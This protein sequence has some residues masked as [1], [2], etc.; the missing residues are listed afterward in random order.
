MYA[1]R[2][3]QEQQR[4]DHLLYDLLLSERFE[5]MEF[6]RGELEGPSHRVTF[7]PLLDGSCLV[8]YAGADYGRVPVY[9]ETMIGEDERAPRYGRLIF[10]DR[11]AWRRMARMLDRCEILSWDHRY[12]GGT[13]EASQ[14]YLDISCRGRRRICRAGFDA[15]PPPWE[16]FIRLLQ[17]EIDSRIS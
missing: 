9:D 17:R 12:H 1:T 15:Y 2:I 16:R 14:W 13:E 4:D 5:K 6:F 3:S 8:Q 11:P 10:L 7:Q